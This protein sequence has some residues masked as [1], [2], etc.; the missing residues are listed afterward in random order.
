[1]A[2]Q[3]ATNLERRI[4]RLEWLVKL[5]DE[6]ITAHIDTWPNCTHQ[7]PIPCASEYDLYKVAR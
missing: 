3:D 7:P 1:M 4:A 6:R 5:L 2:T